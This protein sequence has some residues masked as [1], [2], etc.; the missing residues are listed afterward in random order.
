MEVKVRCFLP[1]KD[2]VVLKREDSEGPIR[3]DKRLRGPLRRDHD[4]LA[5]LIRKI[6]QGGDMPTCDDAA[7]A[8][9]E[10]PG[11]YHGERKLALIYDCPSFFPTCHSFTKVTRISQR[12]FNQL[13]SPI[14][15]ANRYKN[16]C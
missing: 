2:P 11:I 16:V 9:F 13:P 10:L 6:E 12:K 4:S 15:P 1:A 14:R 8:N 7:L 5:F 3:L